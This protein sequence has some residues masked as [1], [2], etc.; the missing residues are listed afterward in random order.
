M[1]LTLH[2]SAA[3]IYNSATEI[4][5]DYDPTRLTSGSHHTR[6]T[7]KHILHHE[8]MK[9]PGHRDDKEKIDISFEEGL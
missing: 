7:L 5:Q 3:E 1:W 9:K 8:D 6:L 2:N 4:S